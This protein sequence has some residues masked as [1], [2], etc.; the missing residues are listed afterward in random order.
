MGKKNDNVKNLVTE[1]NSSLNDVQAEYCN[2]QDS[3]PWLD[4]EYLSGCSCLAWR[5]PS[6]FWTKYMPVA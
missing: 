6:F 3:P 5:S 1:K 2:G 4:T